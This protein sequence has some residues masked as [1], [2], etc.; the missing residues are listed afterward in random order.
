MDA[1]MKLAEVIEKK[2]RDKYIGNDDSGYLK[3]DWLI[4][5]IIQIVKKHPQLLK[6]IDFEMSIEKIMG[7]IN[8]FIASEIK[9]R[10]LKLAKLRFILTEKWQ[11]R[12]QETMILLLLMGYCFHKSVIRMNNNRVPEGEY[13][14][15]YGA[16]DV[17]SNMAYPMPHQSSNNSLDEII[18]QLTGSSCS[19]SDIETKVDKLSKNSSKT[20]INEIIF[21]NSKNRFKS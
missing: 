18:K 8:D 15:P 19:S 17:I 20:K 13:F 7:I 21:V 3:Q 2:Y 14:K 16:E 6:L 12:S 9:R 5:Q 10:Q 11:C 1:I 4:Y